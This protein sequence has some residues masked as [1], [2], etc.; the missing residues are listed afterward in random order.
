MRA[1]VDGSAGDSGVRVVGTNKAD[2]DDEHRLSG[3]NSDPCS[4]SPNVHANRRP[5]G[6]AG[7]HSDPGS[8]N[9]NSRAARHGQS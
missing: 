1:S 6:Y 7:A 5:D 8:A 2:R 4:A 3:A 9:A